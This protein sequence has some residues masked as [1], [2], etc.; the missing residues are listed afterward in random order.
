MR[1][2]A[3]VLLTFAAAGLAGL[4][5][6]EIR[7][8]WG[9]KIN[10]SAGLLQKGDYKAALKIDERLIKDMEEMLG[11]GDAGAQVFGTVVTHKALAEAGL[12]KY[13]DAL[14]YWHTALALF[15]RL[16][17]A[18]LSTFG[19][20]GKYLKEHPPGAVRE[21]SPGQS[22][23][24]P[25]KGITAPKIIKKV[26]PVYPEG[27]NTFDVG[28]LLIVA[29]II[30]KEGRVTTPH[31]LRALPAPTLSYAALEAVHQWRFEPGRIDGEA[32][33]VVFNLTVNYKP[34]R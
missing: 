25:A 9:Q 3:I 19:E 23:P 31:V 4:R 24:M 17:E 8:E 27:A 14:W 15:P 2:Q 18:D 22:M 26:E 34:R 7:R 10:Q 13:D 11:P 21:R 6:D 30:D 33:P 12:G 32:V 29:V 5:E 28:G 16:V 20:A 1:L